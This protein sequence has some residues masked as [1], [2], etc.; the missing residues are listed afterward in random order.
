MP[1]D[2]DQP[3]HPTGGMNARD[4]LLLQGEQLRTLRES[5]DRLT[6]SLDQRLAMG[7]RRF[8]EIDAR[9]I[10][11]DSRFASTNTAINAL[12]GRIVDQETEGRRLRESL[13]QAEEAREKADREAEHAQQTMQREWDTWKT[14]IQTSAWIAGFVWAL[15]QFILPYV[16]K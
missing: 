14:R 8:A 2:L 10:T 13:K 4:M 7:D 11:A 5:L 3:L 15:F 9:L 1:D 16:L 6:T 12:S